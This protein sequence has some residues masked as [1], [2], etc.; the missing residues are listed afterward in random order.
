MNTR[1]D[2]DEISRFVVTVIGRDENRLLLLVNRS[3]PQ[4]LA[5]FVV[6][7][8]VEG[9]GWDYARIQMR[10]GDLLQP[11]LVV[12]CRDLKTPSRIQAVQPTTRVTEVFIFQL[13]PP[14]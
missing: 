13:D 11:A 9:Y 14:W 6:D 7:L 1:I 5:G 3:K 8:N 10:L 2:D 12:G 4:L